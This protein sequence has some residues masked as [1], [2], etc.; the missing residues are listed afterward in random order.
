MTWGVIIL[1]ATSHRGWLEKMAIQAL[2]GTPKAMTMDDAAA[3][4]KGGADI[5][6]TAGFKG[7]QLH[8]AHGSLLSQFYSPHTNRQA[9]E[10]GGSSEGHMK[11]LN[12]LVT[13]IRAHHP[14]RFCLSVKLI[15]A[16]T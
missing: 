15:L 7:R 5:T 11:L 3:D 9:D 10:Y 2:L 14:P 16:T 6:V 12:R 13:E 4:W 1:A 8:G